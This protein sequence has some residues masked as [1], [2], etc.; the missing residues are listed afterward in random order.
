MDTDYNKHEKR[1]QDF[2]FLNELIA[3]TGVVTDS[4]LNK[5]GTA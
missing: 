4:S 1:Q 3:S 2:R 5:D